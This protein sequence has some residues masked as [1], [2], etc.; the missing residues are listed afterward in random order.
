[1]KD[2][3]NVDLVDDPNWETARTIW[4]AGGVYLPYKKTKAASH[5]LTDLMRAAAI[6][7]SAKIVSELDHGRTWS[8]E[9]LANRCRDL[10]K[11]LSDID[12]V[13][14]SRIAGASP[15]S[16]KYLLGESIANLDHLESALKNAL[17]PLIPYKKPHEHNYFLV[18]ILANI[19]ELS[20][21]RKATVTTNP[22]T[23]EREG[24]FVAFV[25]SFVENFLPGQVPSMNP[26]AIQTALKQ[27]RDNP[28]HKPDSWL[29]FYRGKKLFA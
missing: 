6:F 29:W 14:Y 22:V 10:S 2:D 25:M 3:Q 13:A 9:E 21:E 12:S 26:R 17:A 18:V 11:S 16:L 19:Y 4:S 7:S 28:E 1:M 23:D 5:Y 27:R 24:F 20:A 15:V 8:F